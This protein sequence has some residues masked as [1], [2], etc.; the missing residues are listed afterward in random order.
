MSAQFQQFCANW[1]IDH[2]TSSPRYAQS[3]GLDERVVQSAKTLLE[4]F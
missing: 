1:N 3:N 4:C 2:V